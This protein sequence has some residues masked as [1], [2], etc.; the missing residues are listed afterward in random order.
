MRGHAD[1][2]YR[3][4]LERELLFRTIRASE[5]EAVAAYQAWRA[6][7]DF[8]GAID[9]ET[10]ALLP[11][12]HEVLQR[13][14]IDDPLSGIFAGVARRAWY[15]NH[16][17]LAGLQQAL[18]GLAREQIDCVLVGEVPLVLTHYKSLYSRRIGQADIVVS[19][20]QAQLAAWILSDAGWAAD[21][22]LAAEEVTYGHVKRFVGPAAHVLN[23]HWHFIGSASGATADEFFWAAR[24]P[25]IVNG[26]QAW[27][28]APTAMLLHSLLA[29]SLVLASMPALWLIDELALMAGTEN[30]LD[31][32]RIVAFAMEEKLALRLRRKLQLL[33]QFG[34]S[35]PELAAKML[36]DARPNLP[37]TIDRVMLGNR[38]Q[39]RQPAPVG[40]RGVLA[41]YLRSDRR[42]GL[43]HGVADFSHFVRYRWGLRGRR[44]F[45]PVAARHVCRVA[46]FTWR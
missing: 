31:W 42:P 35:I 16:T 38:R 21:S 10:A 8:K 14:R 24:Q 40:R 26:A 33:G 41:D 27:N 30:E 43:L 18:D 29:D 25:C 11:L 28:L 7:V 44:E 19:P 4:I 39:Q 46:G 15:E 45:F 34:V 37:E 1:N 23:L 12:L 13:L 36:L 22:P 5:T 32:S 17:L 9:S 2:S 6:T 20:G 3:P